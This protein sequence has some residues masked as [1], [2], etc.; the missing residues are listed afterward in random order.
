MYLYS[1]STNSR[2]KKAKREN[3]A[4]KLLLLLIPIFEPKLFTQYSALQGLYIVLNVFELVYFLVN[5]TRS[6]ERYLNLP[7]LGWIAY[8]IY[9]LLPMTLNNNYGGL[10]QWGRMSLTVLNAILLF[11][12]AYKSN[13]EKLVKALAA[14]G[15]CLLSINLVSVFMFPNGIIEPELYYMRDNAIYFLGIKTAFTTMIFPTVAAAG[16]L[17]YMNR[18]KYR[19]LLAFS[20]IVSILNI[21]SKMISTAVIGCILIVLLVMANKLFKIDL[22]FPL[23]VLLAV[24]LQIGVVFFNIQDVF[25]NL[26]EVFFNKDATLSSRTYIWGNAKNLILSSDTLNLLFG[27]GMTK[28]YAFVPYGDGYWQPHN[29]LLV[30]LYTG[31]LFGTAMISGF[32]CL[33]SQWKARHNQLYIFLS[34]MSFAVLVLSVTEVYFDV[35]SCYIPILLLHY[36]EAA[37]NSESEDQESTGSNNRLTNF[38]ETYGRA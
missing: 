11:E 27:S 9:L 2:L 18:K 33:L 23:L 20:I 34:I 25:S 8:C 21:F 31:G 19:G 7:V 14:Y 24:L 13:F 35:A 3:N 28:Q 1:I 16:T 17:F 15:I 12:Y 10:L 32:F 37:A 6:N 22:P 30:W 38:D 4:L 36:A 26:F 5:L 29:Q